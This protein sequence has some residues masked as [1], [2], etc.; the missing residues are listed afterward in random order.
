MK[1]IDKSEVSYE[2]PITNKH[3]GTICN[4][5]SNKQQLM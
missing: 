1:I 3:F 4:T 2:Y 5:Q